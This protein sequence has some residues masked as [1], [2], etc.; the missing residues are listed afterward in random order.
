[1]LL[2]M[3]LKKNKIS[4]IIILFL[5]ACMWCSS[6]SA[7]NKYDSP[8]GKVQQLFNKKNNSYTIRY[9]HTFTDTLRIPNNCKIVFKGGSLRG[10]IEFNNTK[11]SGIPDMKGATV[12]GTVANDQI[13]ASWFCYMDGMTDDAPSINSIINICNKIH[14]EKGAYFL[15]KQHQI[16]MN[17]HGVLRDRV[18]APIGITRSNLTLVG[19]SG[20]NFIVSSVD[21]TICIYSKPYDTTNVCKNI[22]IEGITFTTKNEGKN[23]HEF[24]NSI[25]I[26]GVKGLVIKN[27]IFNDFWG[28]AIC[29]SHYC[30][31]EK[32]GERTRN[33]NV[34]IINNKIVGGK[35][36]NTRN[37][38]S[39]ISGEN[40]LIQ[41]NS[42]CETTAE[43]MPGAIDIE[44]DNSVY[45]V[46][47]IRII[48]NVIENCFGTAGGICVHTNAKGGPAFDID[49]VGNYIKNCTYGLAFVVH[50]NYKSGN[51]T[52]RGNIV[53]SDT[54]PYVFYGNG[55]STNWLFSNNQ[56]KKKTWRKIGG[57]MKIIGLTIKD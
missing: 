2:E 14:F 40:V 52:V 25:K 43:E 53:E 8:H 22:S 48:N 54:E 38:I 15:N 39:I 28:D 9:N 45:T 26:I 18:T 49:I 47:N 20:A 11:I 19:D 7:T 17:L 1:M 27:C 29:L 33:S 10:P 36:H 37:G 23:F 24:W 6:L 13:E 34:S 31:D 51:I 57:K 46:R 30:D 42:I 56:F 12:S 41:G 16:N 3:L 4:S 21:N 35:H 50:A 44:A 32:T 5:V 55:K